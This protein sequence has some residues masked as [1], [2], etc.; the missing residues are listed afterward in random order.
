MPASDLMPVGVGGVR[1]Q[2]VG[3]AAVRALDRAFGRLDFE[4]NARMTQRAAAVTLNAGGVD[5]NGL[6]CVGHDRQIP[7]ELQLMSQ[8]SPQLC[9]PARLNSRQEHGVA[10]QRAAP[11]M[12]RLKNDIYQQ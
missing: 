8:I 10:G 5:F 9:G 6:D 1:I 11:Y 2:D 7:S 12:K 4:V 3:A